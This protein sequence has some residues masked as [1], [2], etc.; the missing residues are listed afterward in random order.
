MSDLRLGQLLDTCVLCGHHR[1]KAG[2]WATGK[3]PHF[4]LSGEGPRYVEAQSSS[5]EAEA[6][7]KEGLGLTEGEEERSEKEN[8]MEGPC[9]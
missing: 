4:A 8:S 5:A 9:G 6:G 7:G 1:Y 3:S 2:T